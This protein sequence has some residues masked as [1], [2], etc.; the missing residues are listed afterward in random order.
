[1]TN[2]V[3]NRKKTYANELNSNYYIF[4]TYLRHLILFFLIIC[5]SY[6]CFSSKLDSHD[7]QRYLLKREAFL[8]LACAYKSEC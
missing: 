8:H 3:L 4:P 5:I 7:I 1:M 6:M 2:Y